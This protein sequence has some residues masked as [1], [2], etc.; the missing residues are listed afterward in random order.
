MSL[1]MTIKVKCKC[2]DSCNQ[3]CFISKKYTCHWCH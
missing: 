1:Q 2:S 3:T